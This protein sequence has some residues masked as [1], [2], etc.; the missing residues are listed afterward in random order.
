[1]F[2]KLKARKDITEEEMDSAKLHTDF[3]LE[4]SKGC[5]VYLFKD[6]KLVES[7]SVVDT[8]KKQPAPNVAYGRISDGSV[9]WGYELK[10]T[11]G[12]AN[13]GGVCKRDHILGE[14]IFSE[15]GSVKTD[16]SLI[17]LA[18]SLP[19]GSPEG[20]RIHFTTSGKEPSEED[21][22]YT[23]QPITITQSTVVRA[24]LFC[25]GWLSPISTTHSYIFLGREL[26]LPVISLSTNESYL[27]DSI[28]GIFSNNSSEK[29]DKYKNWRRPV[30]LEYFEGERTKSILNQLCEMRVGGG[31]TR[32]NSRK[33]LIIYAHKRF[34]EK[35]FDHE[36]FPDQKPGLNKFKSLSLRNAGNDFEFLYMRDALAQRSMGMHVDLDWQAWR[37]AIVF[38]NGY[39]YGMLNIRERDDDDYIYTNYNG[40][41]NIDMFE[42]WDNFKAG[43]WDNL[44]RFTDFYHQYYHSMA[45]YEQWMDCVEFINLMIM[46]LYYCN[47]DFPGNNIVMWRPRTEGGRWR[48]IAKDLDYTMGLY[49]IPYDYETLKWFYNPHFDQKW[50]WN[51]NGYPYTLLFRQLMRDEDFKNLFV[52]R[53]AIYAGDFLNYEGIHK[54]FE[55]MY[56]DISYEL[57]Y[58]GPLIGIG[59]EAY[60]RE[61]EY[62]DKWAKERS[63]EFMRQLCDFY[64]MDKP[65]PLVINNISSEN[66]VDRLT[67]NGHQL[68]EARYN[69]RYFK[70]HP[71]RLTAKAVEG[72][73]VVG[74]RIQR[75]DGLKVST[76]E[77]QGTTL[78]MTMPDCNWLTIEPILKE[79]DNA[80]LPVQ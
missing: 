46:N 8:L 22:L 52:E 24:K 40:L 30:N 56:K 9:K 17:Q 20:T 79:A 69:G 55:A 19:E 25:E 48:W 21:N 2:D 4:S 41:E 29:R 10:A 27:Q 37:P 23:G 36:F 64:N 31:A 74:W 62:V 18:L 38:I 67:F 73:V 7:A 54:L 5:V 61:M 71:I 33:T 42:N 76:E 13:C 80:Y 72:K 43:D 35:L 65:V 14:P 68:S 66:L 60:R 75:T 77:R 59:H 16:N 50:R 32:E 34:G 51:A 12:Y 53:F 1:M 15:L 44:N 45:E 39:Y 49:G 70:N 78:K 58:Y 57:S 11:P 3:R 26:T 47:L 6:G 28:V 63:D